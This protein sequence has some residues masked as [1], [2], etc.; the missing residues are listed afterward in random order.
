MALDTNTNLV[1]SIGTWAD[2]N[3]TGFTAAIP[4]FIALF[5]ATANTELPLRT[6]FNLKTTTITMV[7][8]VQSFTL[9]SDFLEAKT[10]LNTTTTP[11]QIIPITNTSSLYTTTPNVTATG[12]PKGMAVTGLYGETSPQ[13]D[14]AYALKLYYYANVPA[15]ATS[16]TNWLL[17]NFPNTY[18]FGTL[19]AAEAFLGTDPRI[20]LWG[21]L[22]DNA[23]QKI[24][25]AT[26][27]GQYGG[28]PLTVRV[29]AVV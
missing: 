17:T 1:T 23:M 10:L 3:D 28:S 24:S 21:D 26:E 7:S 2:R 22:Y 5:E 8:G 9:P 6:R 4:D 18:L 15:L 11:Y 16:E 29:D 12:A 19:L 27:R 13:P 20:K 25:G 14:Q